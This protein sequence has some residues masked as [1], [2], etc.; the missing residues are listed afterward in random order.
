MRPT[1]FSLDTVTGKPVCPLVRQHL[2]FTL[3]IS[4][5][6]TVDRKESTLWSIMERARLK[7]EQEKGDSQAVILNP[8]E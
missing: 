5:H 4:C 2:L 1:A 8:K 7:A 6:L 3:L